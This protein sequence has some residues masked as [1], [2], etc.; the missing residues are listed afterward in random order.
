MNE[1][2][3]IK[4][5]TVPKGKITLRSYKAG[6]KELLQEIVT[7]N[8]I[9]VGNNTGKDLLVQYLLGL[10]ADAQSG[11]AYQ[12]GIN[13]GAIGTSN[14]AVNV[15]DTQLGT[16]F[17]RTVVSFYQDLTNSEA[18]IQFFFPD[19]VLTNQT[20]YEF[21]TFVN[22]TASANSGQIF[23]HALF[24]TPYAKTAGTDTTVEVDVTF[25]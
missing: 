24:S 23:N 22:G 21:G 11:A 13:Y 7:D 2:L 4:D 9:M 20:Y 25:T 6:T 12:G 14:T 3:K 5:G 17:A 10:V 8:L 19:G 15:A 1:L 18:A 16:E